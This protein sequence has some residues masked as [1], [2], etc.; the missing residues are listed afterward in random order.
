MFLE[1]SMEMQSEYLNRIS[2]GTDVS[3]EKL[4]FSGTRVVA[5]T[6][7]LFAC[8]TRSCEFRIYLGWGAELHGGHALPLRPN[9]RVE[10]VPHAR[11]CLHKSTKYVPAWSMDPRC[12]SG[13]G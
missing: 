2:V 10:S 1:Y 13:N 7:K 4:T 8:K 9:M 3:Y 5:V 11:D 12:V 6:G